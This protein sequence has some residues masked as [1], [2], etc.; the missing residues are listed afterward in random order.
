MQPGPQEIENRVHELRRNHPSLLLIDEAGRSTQGRPI[1]AVTVTDPA[2]PDDDKE[3]ALIIAGQHGD[4][5]TPRATALALLEWLVSPAAAATRRRQ[6]IV[7]MPCVNPDGAE[8]DSHLTATGI[9]P[10][11]DHGPDGP[12]SP[13]GMAVEKIAYQLEPELFVDMHARGFAGCSFDM[14]LYPATRPYTED[15]NI[16]H[17]VAA[18]MALAGEKAGIPHMTHPLTWPGW[19]GDDPDEPSTTLFAYRRFKSLVMLTESAESNAWAYPMPLRVKAGLA[20]VRCALD[21]GNRRYPRLPHA[22]YP[23]ALVAGMFLSGI[24]AMGDTAARRRQSRIE[25]WRHRDAFTKLERC[26]PEQDRIKKLL[27]HYNGPPLR[28]PVGVQTFAAGR[29]RLTAAAFDQK[30]LAATAQT[31]HDGCATLTVIPVEHLAPG[32]HEIEVRYN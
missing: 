18:R 13:E 24:V 11:L 20:R 27:L 23:C 21:F 17:A 12:R 15:D 3:H 7:V 14:V 10:N 30:D 25:A 9:A 31:W 1:L 4:E 2:T 28:H 19:G 8:A 22:G 32:T 29:L 6:K 26:T 16:F 5:E